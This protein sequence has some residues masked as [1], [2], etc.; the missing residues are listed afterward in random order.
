VSFTSGTNVASFGS[1]G[2]TAT[3]LSGPGIDGNDWNSRALFV[4][5]DA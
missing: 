5:S 1:V 3:T 4:R 2:A